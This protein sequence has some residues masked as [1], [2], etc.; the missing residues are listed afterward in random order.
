MLPRLCEKF[1]CLGKMLLK[2]GH[3]SR[4]DALRMVFKRASSSSDH[5]QPNN[6]LEAVS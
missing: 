5:K 6:I 2:K 1:A 3:G 4:K